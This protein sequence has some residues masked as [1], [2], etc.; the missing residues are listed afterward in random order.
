MEQRDLFSQLEPWPR[1]ES[2][3]TFRRWID[4][5]EYAPDYTFAWQFRR[6]TGELYAAAS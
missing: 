2:D 4:S 5:N 1:Y 3:A 6:N